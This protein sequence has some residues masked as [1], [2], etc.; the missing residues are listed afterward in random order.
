[1]KR[2]VSGLLLTLAISACGASPKA[3]LQKACISN[4]SASDAVCECIAD[5]ADNS[6]EPAEIDIL[7]QAFSQDDDVNS[8]GESAS[9]LG[10]GGAAA[11]LMKMRGIVTECGMSV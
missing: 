6:L 1:M 8:I 9:E 5:A 11:F 3:S 10:I 2:V 7:I 4:G